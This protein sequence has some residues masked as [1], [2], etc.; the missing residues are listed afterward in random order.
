MQA[1]GATVSG[2]SSGAY[3]AVQ[4][5]LSQ[6]PLFALGVVVIDIAKAWIASRLIRPSTSLQPPSG[7]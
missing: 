6:G 3:M 4:L 7:R 2:V 1:E 5:H